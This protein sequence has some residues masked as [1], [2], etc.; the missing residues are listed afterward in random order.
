MTVRDVPK[1]D[2]LLGVSPQLT[3]ELAHVHGDRPQADL[4]RSPILPKKTQL[5]KATQRREIIVGL[6]RLFE[7]QGA[8]VPMGS[9]A[10]HLRVRKQQLNAYF[11][12]CE[13]EGVSIDDITAHVPCGGCTACCH[14]PVD[15]M[16]RETGKG[17]DYELIN[18]GGGRRLRQNPD[19]SCIHLIDGRCSVYEH[20]PIMCRRYDC[21]DVALMINI[22]EPADETSTDAAIAA[23]I[24]RWRPAFKGDADVD[25]FL[26]VRNFMRQLTSAA[27]IKV[28]PEVAMEYAILMHDLRNNGTEPVPVTFEKLWEAARGKA[29]A[30][31]STTMGPRD[32]HGEQLDDVHHDVRDPR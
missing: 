2:D 29:S 26:Q 14:L 28:P 15:L 10:R 9:V 22:V 24:R 31:A 5:S 4:T 16:P 23:M 13:G 7:R 6:E 18:S 3:D 30:S 27:P 32:A 21:R 20:R 25:A 17:L 11:D 1:L 19:G 12:Y 8:D